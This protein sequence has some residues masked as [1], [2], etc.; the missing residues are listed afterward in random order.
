MRFRH[1]MA[2]LVPV[3][4]ASAFAVLPIGASAAAHGAAVPV[5]R[6]VPEV[7]SPLAYKYVGKAGASTA[8]D[9]FSFTCQEPGASPNCYTPRELA[10]AYDIPAKLTGAGQTI[11]IIDAFGD[12][13][14]G[15]D[16]ATEES[17]F[18]LPHANVSIIYPNGKPAFNPANA[19]EVNWTGEIAL[20]V[21]SAHAVAPAAKIDL[22]IAKSDNDPDMLN[23]LKYTVSHHLGSVL[24]QSY[25]EAESC[26]AKSIEQADHTLFGQAEA[27]NMSVFAASGDNG[28]AQPSCNNKSYVKS[29]SLPAADPLVTSVGAT[30]L[31]AAQPGGAYKSET[32]WNDSYGS[33]GGGYSTIFA[34]PSY[35]SGFVS[36]GHRGVPDVSYS[37]DVNNGL[38]IAWSQGDATQVGNIYE[39]GGTSAATPQWAAIA[40]LANQ[41]AHHAL[42]FLNAKL[43]A[44]AH[45]RYSTVFRD[46]TKGN[47]TVVT[48]GG[49]TLPITGSTDSGKV[50]VSGY[51]TARGW[52]AVTGLGTPIVA[53]L[54]QY[55][56]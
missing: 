17:T 13:T 24:S 21:E 20:D 8:A 15:Q 50:R 16:L 56:H 19:N 36:S 43:Y 10:A 46:V 54:L 48:G 30:S 12:P 40:A 6:V 4:V 28:A 35:Q 22:V 27:K 53:H 18:G 25:G 26:E 52:D 42:G 45:S 51:A 1:V 5:G 44:L 38:L 9:G 31:T 37:G 11:V 39:F 32:A 3:G 23:A 34:R 33:S 29:A 47:N 49:S 41:N 2:G 7:A 14:L 55:L